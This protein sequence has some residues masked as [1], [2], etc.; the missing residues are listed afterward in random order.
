MTTLGSDVVVIVEY[1]LTGRAKDAMALIAMILISLVLQMLIV[2]LKNRKSKNLLKELAIVL[3]GVKPGVDAHR[4]AS[5]QDGLY[6]KSEETDAFDTHTELVCIK[7]IEVAAEAIPGSILQTYVMLNSYEEGKSISATLMASLLI[8]ALTS[9]FTTAVITYDYD[10]SPIRRKLEPA[11]YGYIPSGKISRSL[12]FLN[13]VLNGAV[14]LLLRSAGAA[15]LISLGSEYLLGFFACD[16]ALLIFIKVLAR[17]LTYWI[18]IEG[19]LVWSVFT[20]SLIRLVMKLV[21][22]FTGLIQWRMPFD[23]GGF[24]YNFNSVVAIVVPFV[25]LEAYVDAKGEEFDASA[26]RSVITALSC[27]WLALFGTFLLLMQPGYKHT[28]F[29]TKTGRK[30]A[31]EYFTDS[32]D[33]G[34]KNQILTVNARL[35]APIR[36]DVRNWTLENWARWEEEKPEWFTGDFV[37]KV[38]PDQSAEVQTK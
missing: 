28:F 13:M 5:Q 32:D 17:D 33:D 15:I 16:F 19:G 24:Y 14:L 31:Q 11:M 37:D 35:W 6:E 8:S 12:I 22:D 7:V 38:A 18:P 23:F 34:R 21:L 26:M 30:H 4:V 2:W 10:V 20:S 29:N 36:D 27:T 9:G 3:S 25:A 1:S